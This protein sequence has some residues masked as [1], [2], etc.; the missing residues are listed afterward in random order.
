MSKMQSE[1]L[2]FTAEG[3]PPLEII[4]LFFF[5]FACWLVQE[6]SSAAAKTVN[7]HKR[8]FSAGGNALLAYSQ[9]VFFYLF[10]FVYPYFNNLIESKKFEPLATLLS[11]IFQR[12]L[13]K[14][15]QNYN[16]FVV[17][18]NDKYFFIME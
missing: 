6:S 2:T 1:G 7:I 3:R 17:G 12:K 11:N 5:N 10:L 15:F 16:H 14:S 18:F 8:I 4:L 9:N 13:F